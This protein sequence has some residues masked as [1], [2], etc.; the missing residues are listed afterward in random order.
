MESHRTTVKL[1]DIDGAKI[2][3][4]GL[5]YVGLPLGAAFGTRF[6]TLGFDLDAERVAALREGRDGNGEV[7]PEDLR[8]AGL[9]FSDDPADL[10]GRDVFVVAVPTPIDRNR[11]PDLGPLLAA[12]RTVGEAIAPGG[13]VIF[14]STVYPGATED[15]CIPVVEAVS[16][17]A[18]GRDFHAGYSPERINPGDRDRP[19]TGIVKVTSGSSP[20]AA[21]FVDALYAAVITAGT[22]KAASIRVAEAAKVIENTQRDVNIALVNELS[23]VFS[24]MGIDTHDVIDAAA[25]KWNFLRMTPG[26]VGGHCIGVDPYYLMHRSMVAG[27]IPDIIRRAREINEGMARHAAERLVKAMIA[28][29]GRVRGA[30]ILVLGLTFKEDCADIRNTKV[31]D[32]VRALESYGMRVSTYDPLADRDDARAACGLELMP[33]LPEATGLFDAVVLAVPHAPLLALGAQGLR[34]LLHEGGVLFDLK[35]AL[36]RGQSD[37]RL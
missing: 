25:T 32:L 9:S 15:D 33:S 12:S 5:G 4:I 26:L 10:R 8:A 7:P 20:E 36:P 27:H 16:G 2:A 29:D 13:V 31:V 18:L 37:L 23:M 24:M 6:D 35:A 17:L 1:P 30:Q 28:R 34:A 11:Q 19:V 21:D 3:V 22:F 14:E